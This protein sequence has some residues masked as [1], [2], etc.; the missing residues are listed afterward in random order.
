LSQGTAEN[1]ARMC[2]ELKAISLGFPVAQVQKMQQEC[3]VAEIMLR[4]ASS[5]MHKMIEVPSHRQKASQ[6]LF[7]LV[8]ILRR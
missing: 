8:L 5:L 1:T 2:E 6:A 4:R 3:G 7:I